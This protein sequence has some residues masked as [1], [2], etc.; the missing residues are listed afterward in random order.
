ML[1]WNYLLGHCSF[2]RL[3]ILAALG[4]LSRKLLKVKHSKCAGC[5]YGAMTKRPWQT[6]SVINQGYIREASAPGEC[7]SVD[8]MESIT[9]WFI[10]QLKGNP[11]KQRYC[12][13]TIFLDRYSD[14]TYVHLQRVS[15]SEET[16]EA[17]KVFEA[18]ARTYKVKVR[19][20]HAYNGRFVDNAFQQAVTQ[21]SQ[22]ISYC[23]VNAHFQNGKAEKR[24]RDLQ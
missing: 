17:K 14:L 22:T 6:K 1:L 12:A 2:K 13:E 5:L 11:T 24:I 19:H 3:G 4:I 8:Q 7:I 16:V 9:P 20:Y 21:E 23:V 18:Y 10:A 15:L